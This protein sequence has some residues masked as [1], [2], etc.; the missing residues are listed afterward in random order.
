MLDY[1]APRRDMDFLLFDLFQVD[2]AWRDVPAFADFSSDLVGA[3][4]DEAGKLASQVMAPVNQSGD[5]EGCRFDNGAV[6]TPA[7]FREAFAQL[8]D[9]GWMGLSGN[10][11]YGGQGM[12]KLLGCAL[13]EMFWA[14]NSSLYL[15]GTLTVG[16]AICIDAHGSEDQKTLYLPKLYAGQWTGA[17]AL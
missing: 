6:T 8:A 14:A 2:R 15:Y 17:M 9:G 11:A 5:A 10:P 3:V 12:P 4:V 16:A 7:G 1:R 13:E